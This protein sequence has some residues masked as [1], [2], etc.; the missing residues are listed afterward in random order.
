MSS[1]QNSKT[2]MLGFKELDSK[3]YVFNSNQ[4][5]VYAMKLMTDGYCVGL[6]ANTVQDGMMPFSRQQ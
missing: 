1:N 4:W 3:M 2:N 6:P 5:R